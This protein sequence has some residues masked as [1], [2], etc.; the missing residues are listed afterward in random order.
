M[1]M[2]GAAFTNA[3]FM[4]PRSTVIECFSPEFI[5]TGFWEI[6]SLLRHRYAMVVHNNAY[7]AYEYGQALKVNCFQLEL[8]LQSFD[9]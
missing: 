2:H 8:V 4:N 5:N 3:M 7:G 1:G 6:C 9:L